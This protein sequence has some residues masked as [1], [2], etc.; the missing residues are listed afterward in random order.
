MKVKRARKAS[1]NQFGVVIR[2]EHW[3]FIAGSWDNNDINCVEVDRINWRS[4]LG[5]DRLFNLKKSKWLKPL[6]GLSCRASSGPGSGGG[7]GVLMHV[8]LYNPPLSFFLAQPGQ[9][10][11]RKINQMVSNEPWRPLRC[12][13][14]LLIQHSQNPNKLM[15]HLVSLTLEQTP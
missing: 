1:A 8:G 11:R 13:R 5:F 12:F 6:T 14:E 10:F 3:H 9:N 4:L 2:I 7:F 15:Q